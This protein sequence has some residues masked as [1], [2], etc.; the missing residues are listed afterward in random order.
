MQHT[1]YLAAVLLRGCTSM[2]AWCMQ[3]CTDLGFGY[4]VQHMLTTQ[5]TM[6]DYAPSQY[7]Q[8]HVPF[9]VCLGL[10]PSLSQ[11]AILPMPRQCCVS[12][13]NALLTAQSNCPISPKF[14]CS[15]PQTSPAVPSNQPCSSLQLQYPRMAHYC[16]AGLRV[17]L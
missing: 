3:S 1:T 17:L 9:P 5:C 11:S 7:M 15:H 14:P 8:K 6:T 10:C 16:G 4:E 2:H 13:T 12:S